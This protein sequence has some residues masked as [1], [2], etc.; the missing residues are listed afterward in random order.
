VRPSPP[1]PPPQPSPV[2]PPLPPPAQPNQARNCL[3]I[4]RSYFSS[5]SPLPTPPRRSW[6]R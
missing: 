3:S 2:R 1:S 5:P 4:Y 6:T